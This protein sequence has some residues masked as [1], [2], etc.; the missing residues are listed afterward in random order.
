VAEGKSNVNGIKTKEIMAAPKIN[1]FTLG[2]NGGRPRIYKT[3]EDLERKCIEYF[4][5]CITDKQIITITG[6]CLFLGIHRDTLNGW[7]K[8]KNEFSDIINRAMQ[9]VEIA[10]ETKL[11]TFTFGGAI[12]ALK[13]INKEYWKDKTEQEVSQTITNVAATFGGSAIQPTQESTTDTQLD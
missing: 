6:L 9:S 3:P 8:E 7:R 2:N 10:Y 4:D 1:Y 12:F 5:F 11:D 13:N